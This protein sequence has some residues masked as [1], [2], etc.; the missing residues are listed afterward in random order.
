MLGEL[1][2]PHRFENPERAEGIDVGGVFRALETHR[3]M[4]L[5]AEVVDLIGPHLLDDPLQ[6]AAVA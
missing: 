6:V 2:N 1:E 5:G 4:A 3:H